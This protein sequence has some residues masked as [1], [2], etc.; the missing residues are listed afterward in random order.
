MGSWMHRKRKTT[1][2]RLHLRIHTCENAFFDMKNILEKKTQFAYSLKASIHLLLLLMTDHNHYISHPLP[3]MYPHR[4][5]IEV[6]LVITTFIVL[7]QELS[8]LKYIS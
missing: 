8:Q 6:K 4:D 7:F 1:F 5:Q 2:Q 3:L